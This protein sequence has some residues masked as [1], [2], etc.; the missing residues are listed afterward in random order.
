MLGTS[1]PSSGVSKSGRGNAAKSLRMPV[2]S[3][4][5]LC[6]AEI[7]EVDIFNLLGSPGPGQAGGCMVGNSPGSIDGFGRDLTYFKAICLGRI[8]KGHGG[9]QGKV[10]D[11]PLDN[12]NQGNGKIL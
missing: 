3:A 4:I 5:T 7:P 9:Q 8:P 11:K 12:R 1:S 2:T 6:S 10:E